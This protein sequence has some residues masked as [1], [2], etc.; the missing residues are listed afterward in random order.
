MNKREAL[1]R[2]LSR[3]VGDYRLGEIPPRSPDVIDGWLQQFPDELQEPLLGALDAAFKRTYI[4]REALKAFLTDVATTNRRSPDSNVRDY[5]KKANFL[6]I[7]QG[8]SSQTEI[9]SIF[10]EILQETYGFETDQTGSPGGDFIY[11]DDCI[12]TGNRVRSDLCNWLEGDTPSEVNIQVI[13]PILYEGS[14]WIDKKIQDTA[15]ANGKT[16]HLEKQYRGQLK[17]ENRRTLRNQSDVLWPATLPNHDAVKQY[18]AYLEELGYPP[19][20]RDAGNPGASG[21]FEEDAQKL[22]VEQAFL[23]RGCE[24]RLGQAN[25]PKKVRPLGYNNLDTLGFGSMFVMYRNC[26][27]NTPLALWV[28]HDGYPALFPRKT[29]TETLFEDLLQW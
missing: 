13:T 22:L 1:L 10:D 19:V 9:L 4:S 5:W 14:W 8:G 12:G 24:I 26:P 3:T 27:N 21:I 15:I 23:I 17:L 16:V 29:N 2:S 7:Q 28:T 11:L 25:L 18:S 6:N 20:L